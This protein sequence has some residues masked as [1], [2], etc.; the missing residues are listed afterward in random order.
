MQKNHHVFTQLVK[1]S[2]NSKIINLVKHGKTTFYIKILSSAIKYASLFLS[3][4][5]EYI[6]EDSVP[7]NVPSFA[8]SIIMSMKLAGTAAAKPVAPGTG[9]KTKLAKDK[10]NNKR[11]KK[12]T[13][14]NTN[15]TKLG[16]FPRQRRSQGR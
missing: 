2:S 16:L 1:F 6:V 5:E 15:F 12:N 11:Q 14:K 8:Q 10:P 7:T 9:T 13:K 4:M 3:K